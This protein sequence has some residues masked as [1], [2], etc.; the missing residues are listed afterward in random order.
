M[1]WTFFI[2]SSII[3]IIFYHIGGFLFY[4][5]DMSSS[6]TFKLNHKVPVTAALGHPLDANFN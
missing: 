3:P 5:I 4:L 6:E 1:V 2:V